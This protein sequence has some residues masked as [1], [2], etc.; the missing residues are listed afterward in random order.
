MNTKNRITKRDYYNCIDA[1]INAANDAGFGLPE[2]IT[3]EDLNGFVAH[4]VELLDNK[5]AAAAKRAA[6]K[7]VAGDALREKIYS[8]LTEEPQ[9]L[10]QIVAA[11]GDPGLSPQMLSPRL[12]ALVDLGQ[13]AKVS[14]TVPGIEGGKNRKAT[15]YT[16]A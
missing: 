4:E 2:G 1:L 16:L 11:V 13:A 14:V 8:V 15:A 6:E 10:P 7:R 5:A 9:T 12:K 3:Y